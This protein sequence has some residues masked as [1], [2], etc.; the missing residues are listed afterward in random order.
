MAPFWYYHEL[1]DSI[2]ASRTVLKSKHCMF[3]ITRNWIGICTWVYFKAYTY[4]NFWKQVMCN[5]NFCFIQLK[6]A[7]SYTSDLLQLSSGLNKLDV[8][9]LG[10]I[11]GRPSSVFF[12]SS[13]W[14]FW[15]FC[16]L[17]FEISSKSTIEMSN[18]NDYPSCWLNYLLIKRQELDLQLVKYIFYT[19]LKN[20]ENSEENR[21]F[22]GVSEDLEMVK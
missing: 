7:T 15:I 5:F 6:A 9:L 12:S 22:A 8:L 17:K 2:A 18:W 13:V 11:P 20:I 14:T 21:N 19:P 1:C 16:F 10:R 4:W 3:F